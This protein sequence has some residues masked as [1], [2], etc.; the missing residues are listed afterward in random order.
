MKEKKTQLDKK[1]TTAQTPGGRAS[2]AQMKRQRTEEKEQ[3]EGEVSSG[4]EGDEIDEVDELD[5]KVFEDNARLHD[6]NDAL[7]ERL[8][9]LTAEHTRLTQ[10]HTNLTLHT[11]ECTKRLVD[12]VQELEQYRL[13]YAKPTLQREL[14]ELR[15][16]YEEDRQEA[17]SA[18]QASQFAHEAQLERVRAEVSEAC[19]TEPLAIG[20]SSKTGRRCK[21]V[22]RKSTAG[23]LGSMSSLINCDGLARQWLHRQHSGMVR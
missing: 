9:D 8:A 20:S 19:Q 4:T 12:A 11:A 13:G 17:A 22:T 14:E 5:E 21:I 7:E 18:N 16:R 23:A 1:K 3:E 6:A 10:E 2:S 15:Q